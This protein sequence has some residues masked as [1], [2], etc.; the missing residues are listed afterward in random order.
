MKKYINYNIT[1][2][3][4]VN[5]WGVVIPVGANEGI[6]DYKTNEPLNMLEYPEPYKI[7]LIWLGKYF[8]YPRKP[9]KLSTVS[10]PNA[11][12]EG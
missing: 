10:L 5:K 8:Q 6:V 3:C 4:E 1:I 2:T 9:K 7:Q 11:A 12:A